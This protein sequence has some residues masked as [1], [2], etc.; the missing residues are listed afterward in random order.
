MLTAGRPKKYTQHLGVGQIAKCLLQ[1][2]PT[3]TGLFF[4]KYIY[5]Q[6]LGV[7]QIAKSLLQ[8]SPTQIGLFLEG[9]QKNG[10]L[11]KEPFKIRALFKKSLSTRYAKDVEVGRMGGR[12]MCVR[13][14]VCVCVRVCVC[15]CGGGGGGQTHSF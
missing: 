14:C 9:P 3:Q 11:F 6:H 4:K 15:V 10:A 2:S 12:G 1:K 7:D 8:K 5:T 13:A